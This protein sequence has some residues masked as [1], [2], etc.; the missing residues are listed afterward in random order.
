MKY[1]KFNIKKLQDNY[2]PPGISA[3]DAWAAMNRSLNEG[4]QP[5]PSTP[6]FKF[7][8]NPLFWMVVLMIAIAT[9]LTINHASKSRSKTITKAIEP[10][11]TR[12]I[13]NASTHT[14]AWQSNDNNS[15]S[16]SVNGQH[17]KQPSADSTKM[18]TANLKPN[19]LSLDQIIP[20]TE[21]KNN[22]PAA[23]GNGNITFGATRNTNPAKNTNIKGNGAG[24]LRQEE[25]ANNIAGRSPYNPGRRTGSGKDQHKPYSKTHKDLP[26]DQQYKVA[27]GNIPSAGSGKVGEIE[28]V[29]SLDLTKI[30]SASTSFIIDNTRKI[31]ASAFLQQLND[32]LRNISPDKKGN[33]KSTGKSK[34]ESAKKP[35]AFD[36]G[37][38]WQLPLPVQG[39]TNYFKGANGKSK[40]FNL[41][42]PQLW[43]SK[44]LSARSKLFL[45]F[46]A[47]Q[48]YFI[49]RKE[50]AERTMFMATMDTGISKIYLYKMSGYGASLAWSYEISRSWSASFGLN[51]S[52]N[53][54]ALLDEQTRN[55]FT[56]NI[57]RD[58]LY[59]IS[60]FSNEWR[61]INKSTLAANLEFYYTLKKFDIGVAASV[62]LSTIP[63][64]G[65]KNVH[66]LNGQLFLR[67]NIKRK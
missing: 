53:T 65:N 14:G 13:N 27:P 24:N 3:D 11:N 45:T 25:S 12:T 35:I 41:L 17:N 30:A 44:D 64:Y 47:R 32:G 2:P 28:D 51:Y 34:T 52:L 61:Y 10:N 7:P 67:W 40:P 66:P 39:T 5:Q 16:N 55:T 1:K 38:Q 50:L 36:Y 60:R 8:G 26:G 6:G 37:L 4:L 49:K 46:N 20:A 29:G 62:P 48:Q 54:H 23:P 18:K 57:L 19:V 31:F 15:G 33:I 58:S 9:I 42:Q 56:G 43:I 22:I 63:V 59:G 21:G